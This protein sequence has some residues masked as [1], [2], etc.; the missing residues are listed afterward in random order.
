MWVVIKMSGKLSMSNR[1]TISGHQ[2]LTF[3]CHVCGFIGKTCGMPVSCP[4]C[5]F[6]PLAEINKELQRERDENAIAEAEAKAKTHS[7]KVK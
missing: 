5:G 6:N 1:E 4:R 7:K 2:K 3:E